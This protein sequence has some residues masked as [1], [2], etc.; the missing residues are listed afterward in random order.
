MTDDMTVPDKAAGALDRGLAMLE[1]LGVVRT[2]SAVDLANALG[3][4]RSTAYR[5]VDRLKEKDWLAV[6]S[7]TGMLRLGPAAARLSAAAVASVDLRDLAIPALRALRDTTQETVSLAVP[8]GLNM[9]F[10]HRDR[11][12][13]PVAV[14]DELG[15]SR[16]LHCTSVGRAYLSALSPD[17]LDAVLEDLV[18]S[19]ASPVDASTVAGLRREIQ[20]TRARGWSQDLREFDESSCCAGAPIRDHTGAPI[21]AISVAGVAERMER[22]ID[23]VGPLVAETAAKLSAELGYSAAAQ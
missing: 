20:A 6:D 5:L 9:V 11:G 12:P 23:E 10:V 8:N 18:A 17:R 7:G 1:H 13:R 3:L 21:A 4:S 2:C 15:T 16:P 19:E 14:S 22:I